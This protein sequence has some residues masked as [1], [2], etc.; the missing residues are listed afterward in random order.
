M[1]SIAII[2][3]SSNN[4]DLEFVMALQTARLFLVI[5][6]GPVLARMI[7]RKTIAESSSIS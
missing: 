7:A 5:F 1:D 3:A 4:V 6:I 2:A